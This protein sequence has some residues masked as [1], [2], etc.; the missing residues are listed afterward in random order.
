MGGGLWGNRRGGGLRQI[1][2]LPQSPLTSQF[3]L[4]NDIWHGIL[5]QSNLSKYRCL[6]KPASFA[7]IIK[8]SMGARN[9]VGIGLSNGPPSYPGLLKSLKIRVPVLATRF[10]RSL[11]KEQTSVVTTTVKKNPSC[12]TVPL[13]L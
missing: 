5:Y 10:V 12:E 4:D 7:G 11:Q 1:K 9:R 8:Q 13:F 6:L 3:C 2:H